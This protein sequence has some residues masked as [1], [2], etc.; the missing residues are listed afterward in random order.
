[1]RRLV[2]LLIVVALVATASS[3]G[4]YPNCDDSSLS[5]R[6]GEYDNII[7]FIIIVS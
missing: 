7:F 1:M 4:Q 3:Q 5:C 6:G 2:T